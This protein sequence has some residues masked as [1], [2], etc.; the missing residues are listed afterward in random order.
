MDKMQLIDIG[1][2]LTNKRFRTDLDTVIER[3]KDNGVDHIIVTGTSLATSWDAIVIAKKFP[4]TL[5]ATAGVHPHDAKT[6]VSDSNST[7]KAL[8][9][10][11]LVV[12]IGECGLDFNRNFS[13][14]DK[15]LECFE[16]QLCLA[17]ELNLPVFL[18]ERE[19]H[20]DFFRILSEYRSDLPNAVVHCFT[21]TR[22][23]A[24]AYV[25]LDCHLGITGWLCDERRGQSLRDAVAHIPTNRLMIETDAPFLTPRT[26]QP[27]P[28]NNRNEPAFL[29][30]VLASLA[31]ILSV[32]KEQLA[33]E[34]YATTRN[35]FDLT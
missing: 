14:K 6:W 13:P 11:G 29:P 7:L 34:L 31:E 28:K 8:A 18:H 35:F 19:A 32:S 33:A 16:A 5:K 25:E 15:Q 23:E 30:V 4:D 21:G 12:A 20:D 3:G 2:N 22:Q 26:M 27:R 9:K 10:S 1:A 24:E 17:A